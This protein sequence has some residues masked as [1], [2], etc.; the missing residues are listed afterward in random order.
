RRKGQVYLD[1]SH[2]KTARMKFSGHVNPG[3]FGQSYAHCVVEVDGAA[4]FLGIQSR[5]D[6]IG[7]NRSMG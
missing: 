5:R 3:M 2:L 4:S 1:K 7:N 6:Y